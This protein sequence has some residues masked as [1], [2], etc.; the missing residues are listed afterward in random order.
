VLIEFFSLYCFRKVFQE[1]SSNRKKQPT[2]N[3]VSLRKLDAPG[4]YRIVFGYI[5]LNCQ[6]KLCGLE[7]KDI[8][9]L[10]YFREGKVPVHLF[11]EI[12]LNIQDSCRLFKYDF[13]IVVPISYIELITSFDGTIGSV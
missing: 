11:L 7:Q 3:Y 6:L 5:D 10:N 2:I 4:Y 8:I 13:V 1:Y 12:K 9:Q